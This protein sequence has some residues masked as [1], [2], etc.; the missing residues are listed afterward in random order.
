MQRNQDLLN[1]LR[2]K[3]RQKRRTRHGATESVAPVVIAPS[4][5]PV[6]WI[7]RPPSVGEF[8]KHIDLPGVGRVT[9]DELSRHA[10]DLRTPE[11]TADGRGDFV[12]HVD[13]PSSI[14]LAR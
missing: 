5:R 10:V 13:L 1:K 7:D 8:V 3:I 9:G 11:V 12:V 4:A 2:V 14:S 6:D